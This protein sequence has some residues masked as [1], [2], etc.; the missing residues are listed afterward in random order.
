MGKKIIICKDCK[1]EKYHE[2]RGMCGNCY[3]RWQRRQNPDKFREYDRERWPER[4][5]EQNKKRL[6]R[7]Y[8]NHEENLE[9]NRKYREENREKIYKQQAKYREKNIEKIRARNRRY[10]RARRNIKREL[11][12]L[13]AWSSKLSI[14]E[15]RA[16]WRIQSERRRSR[17]AAVEATLTKDEWEEIKNEYNN[18]CAYC[19][20]SE[21]GLQQDHVIPV[22]KGGPYTAENIVPA[23]IS[24]NSSKSDKLLSE[25]DGPLKFR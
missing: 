21:N 8:A 16:M 22:S 12:R 23:C 15:K 11:A 4:R 1:E 2:A 13:I 25:W 5:D 19:G 6:E 7:Y 18:C 9:K 20:E 17:K 10:N 3:K 24:C 14:E